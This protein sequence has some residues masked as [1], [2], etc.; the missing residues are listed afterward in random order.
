MKKRGK[1][2]NFALLVLLVAATAVSAI[3]CAGKTKPD[4]DPAADDY[5]VKYVSTMPSG[6]DDGVTIDGV[7]SESVYAGQKTFVNYLSEDYDK[8]AE[9][10]SMTTYVGEKGWYV[11]AEVTDSAL[12]YNGLL[13]PARNSTI[14]LYYLLAS[15][16]ANESIREIY[17]DAGRVY[18]RTPCN[19]GL[20]EY[21]VKVNGELNGAT[22]GMTTE[23]FIPWRAMGLTEKPENAD[24]LMYPMYS[25]PKG[26][27]DY[28][29]LSPLPNLSYMANQFYLFGG[30]GYSDKDAD[31]A[32]LGDA[33]NGHVKAGV[34]TYTD[35]EKTVGEDGK[36]T[37]SGTAGVHAGSY[38]KT[39]VKDIVA[40]NYVVEATVK[41]T[42]RDYGKRDGRAGL[43]VDVAGGKRKTF[44]AYISAEEG[45]AAGLNVVP[46]RSFYGD[47]Y[48]GRNNRTTNLSSVTLAGGKTLSDG[49]KLTLIKS[50]ANLYG[51]A[52]GEIILAETD[53][54]IRGK[55]GFNLTAANV[56]AEFTDISYAVYD[57]NDEGMAA[58][59]AGYGIRRIKAETEGYGNVYLDKIAVKDGGEVTLTV[60]CGEDNVIKEIKIN[61]EA[62]TDFA[63]KAEIFGTT[64]RYPISNVTED[65]DILVTFDEYAG[66]KVSGTI[67]VAGESGLNM[68]DSVI[69]AFRADGSVI[70]FEGR[71]NEDGTYEIS[72]PAGAY[73]R[74]R[75]EGAGYANDFDKIGGAAIVIGADPIEN[76]DFALETRIPGVVRHGEGNSV[77]TMTGDKEYTVSG[78][79]HGNAWVEGNFGKAT[80]FALSTRVIAEKPA[81]VGVSLY[82][83][84]NGRNDYDVM[85]RV[86]AGGKM[87][88]S[89]YGW[90]PG[91]ASPNDETCKVGKTYD[92]KDFRLTV[93]RNGDT[94]SVFVNDVLWKTY[95]G[96]ISANLDFSTMGEMR[97]GLAVRGLT[98]VVFRDYT[99]TESQSEIDAI[100]SRI[101][102]VAA[103]DES[104]GSAVVE[105]ITAGRA[106]IGAEV[107]F[108]VTPASGKFIKVLADGKAIGGKVN[109]DGSAVYTYRMGADDVNFTYDVTSAYAVSGTIPED[110]AG[111]TVSVISDGTETVY[112]NALYGTDYSVVLPAGS[113]MIR[114]VAGNREG[115]IENVTVTDGAL[116]GVN[117]AS[118]AIKLQTHKHGGGVGGGRGDWT[119]AGHNKY[120]VSPL[121]GNSYT[122]G[123]LGSGTD[124]VV[125]TRI[126]DG[127][128]KE[129][130]V[131]IDYDGCKNNLFI[132]KT[133]NGNLIQL[134]SWYGGWG[135]AFDVDW[136]GLD[137]NDFEYTV[138]R[139]GDSIY[140]FVGGRFVGSWSGIAYGNKN[141]AEIGESKIGL[142]RRG[143]NDNDSG[144]ATF[145][146]FDFSTDSAK[147][148]EYLYATVALGSTWNDADG[149]LEVGGIEN[150]K[151]KLGS[152]I[153][154]T[155][156][157][158][159]GK[160]VAILANGAAIP[161]TAGENGSTVYTHR[162]TGDVTF[163]YE[164]ENIYAVSGSVPASLDGASLKAVSATGRSFAFPAAVSGGEF[165]VTLPD[166]TYSLYV[167][168]DTH[169]GLIKS[170]IVDGAAVENVNL[171]KAY[172]KP[173]NT[174]VVHGGTAQA[175]NALTNNGEYTIAA[176]NNG[177]STNGLLFGKAVAGDFILSA[178]ISTPTD[179]RTEVGVQINSEA[180]N[181]L[182]FRF[183]TWNGGTSMYGWGS[184]MC[185][186]DNEAGSGKTF[187]KTG[188]VYTLVRKDNAFYMII[189]GTLWKTYSGSYTTTDAWGKGIDLA[190]IG[191][192]DVELAIRGT[193][194]GN[195]F[196][197]YSFS[198]SAADIDAAITA[199]VDTGVWNDTDG[200]RTVSGV[201]DGKA[202]LGDSVVI[203]VTP[204]ENKI[205]KV[206]ANGTALSGE[207]NGDSYVYTYKVNST[208]KIT[209]SY[210]VTN[211]YA[212]SGN[213]TSDLSGA[214]I[215][216]TDTATGLATE[217]KSAVGAGGDYSIA[218]PDGSYSLYVANDTHEGL[219]KSVV[220]GGAA[221]EANLDKAYRIVTQQKY[222]GGSGAGKGEWTLTDNGVYSV[223]PLGDG[224]SYTLG[225][226]G[227]A[228]NFVL[229]A[230]IK[231]GA[232]K[233]VGIGLQYSGKNLMLIKTSNNNLVQFYTWQGEW[234]AASGI[235]WG[236]G[237]ADDFTYTVVRK[238][239]RM[240][241]FVN[242]T[243][244]G[245]FVGKLNDNH[246]LS[247]IGE[248]EVGMLRRGNAAGDVTFSEYSFSTSAADI[249]AAITAVVDTGVWNDTDG[250]RTVSGVTD[251]KAY[252]GDSVVI[253][254][255]P[256]E[257]KIIKVF[258]N[259]TALSG[260]IN[261]DSYVY[262]YKVN[263]T[264]KITF[265]YEVTN[266]YAVSGNVTSDLSGA[267]IK[268]TDTATGLATEYK[269]A[270]GAGGDYSIALPDGS[271]SLYV[272]NDTHEGL[273]KS[274]VVDGAAVEANL[275]KAYI[276]PLS[277]QVSHGGTAQGT[278]TLTDNGEYTIAPAGGS[279]PGNSTNGLLFGKA[280]AGD[281]ILSAKISTPTDMR[282]EV[283]VQIYSAA[284]SILMFRFHTWN[285][286]TSMYGWGSGMCGLDN[287]AGS[288]KT[289]DK[290]G[291][292]Y[293]LV[294]KD[295]A[296]YMF[297]DGT[298]WKTYSGS[299]TTTDTWGKGIDLASIGA[300][301]VE[302]AIRG[303]TTGNKFSDYSFSTSAADID[304]ALGL[305][306]VTGTVADSAN[307]TVTATDTV[308]GAT[309]SAAVANGAYTVAVGKNATYKLYFDCGDKEGL[310]SSVAVGETATVAANATLA[311]KVNWLVT[312]GRTVTMNG[313]GSY[314]VSD[315]EDGA[316]SFGLIGTAAGSDA[317]DSDFMVSARIV[318]GK[319]RH[320]GIAL[321]YGES[322]GTFLSFI[323]AGGSSNVC[324]YNS[325]AWESAAK[326]VN[327]ETGNVDDYTYT[328]VKTGG[329]VKVYVDDKLIATYTSATVGEK[330]YNVSDLKAIDVQV[331]L[332]LCWT[333]HTVATAGTTSAT[334]TDY[335]FSTD[336]AAINDYVTA[337][338][339]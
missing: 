298:L 142:Y 130:G 242:G 5:D 94:I 58:A 260:E 182:M 284:T 77:W 328:V 223:S 104:D 162:V 117:L 287:E 166:G 256:Q 73:D 49:V 187:D 22:T 334:F 132:L 177:N 101:A 249:D 270:V 10:V 232:G 339:A 170:V 253:T 55:C 235:N 317:S 226:M 84:Y 16:N 181:I 202:Y 285:G 276:K 108:S 175:A 87:G 193:T 118:S 141:I 107:K 12:V 323:K 290:T 203:T 255:T 210:E 3:G 50:G 314:T 151:A 127:D 282:T 149:T 72:L 219:I 128:K 188:F 121:G 231:G 234:L 56:N 1:F 46:L 45:N 86:T 248:T 164:I 207:I 318:N 102:N 245:N 172:I 191:A 53:N 115:V 99:F 246:D 119:I 17:M 9:H 312:G 327:W 7:L 64:V 42:G 184:G 308:G 286:G 293:T 300:V 189:D 186:L 138:A 215:K 180:T 31:G 259:G 160:T 71:V 147:I 171:D 185:G 13:A 154:F 78:M 174:Q 279:V 125:T 201:T 140:V 54:A 169:E 43:T 36:V 274:V 332:T 67:S 321:R 136:T 85:I 44:A 143:P 116:T 229:S 11:A 310:V 197:D 112:N 63:E 34:W 158:A 178:K 307:G 206:F 331:G 150:G 80:N 252:L 288:G 214:T 213:V 79:S 69:Y 124:F 306:E 38:A 330:T 303:T 145:Y 240:Y 250:I 304:A 157:L 258:A 194:T 29:N 135:P 8:A 338:N 273:I 15:E 129:L 230:R 281:F 209:F 20:M 241:A 61:G 244:A 198:T 48:D 289:F 21:G 75:V 233:E 111:A 137:K 329:E 35:V 311:Q 251:G 196:S 319:G 114:F 18:G 148:D 134:Y 316:Y 81:E 156:T 224:G 74:I 144:L 326:P 113:Y 295:N 68:S 220:V 261:G 131:G 236:S 173:L 179:M 204:Q 51:L 161:G 337:H 66:V 23:L 265:S 120:T 110:L 221:A 30:D 225:R 324:A 109:A 263:S 95:A 103:L 47:D 199:V 183:H 70:P 2:L 122:L 296:F 96:R 267:T 60:E 133:V 76:A 59:I 291:F 167:A 320:V 88:I 283:G 205:I 315:N 93:V 62:V 257:N 65:T 268:V 24:L 313:T 139:K 19:I 41:V 262:T 227:K 39:Y 123:L 27:G 218:L 222:G 159:A 52:D 32:I 92:P 200:I 243:L 302:L 4:P 238:D 322:N 212:V 195:K 305:V 278:N 89:L 325:T 239:D 126:K 299:Y 266:L 28:R 271:Y 168:N 247:A 14:H 301:D 217:Y 237:N 264:A 292:V 91:W 165:S 33:K 294:R 90:A 192:V 309:Y 216:V 277:T 57:G 208:A 152:D 105:G 275:D 146:N 335:S 211:L 82:G 153:T 40:E 254:V 83:S 100:V 26:G 176:A 155:V 272:A 269:S 190:S 163:T 6:T 25:I 336:S 98:G 97:T 297:I 280:V 37:L 228:K 333:K 106:N